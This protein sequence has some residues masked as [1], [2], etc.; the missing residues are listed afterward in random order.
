[1]LSGQYGRT[2]TK[3]F[4]YKVLLG[5]P[6]TVVG[7][8]GLKDGHGINTGLIRGFPWDWYLDSKEKKDCFLSLSCS[9]GMLRLGLWKAICDG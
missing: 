8:S 1:M 6:S 7:I 9:H 5:L 3:G 4:P 2:V